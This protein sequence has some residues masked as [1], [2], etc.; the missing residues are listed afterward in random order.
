MAD[1]I[2]PES[3]L[4][5]IAD[6]IQEVAKL[7]EWAVVPLIAVAIG[8]EDKGLQEGAWKW[9]RRLTC[10]IS[11]LYTDNLSL[12]Y[13]GIFYFRLM[14]PF[15]VGFQIRWAGKDPYAKEYFQFGF[16]W[17]GNGKPGINFRRQSDLSAAEGYT[18]ANVG[19]AVGWSDGPK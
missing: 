14:F 6:R 19:Q 8:F 12:Y 11:P 5:R 2:K 3:W 10:R 16:G 9:T 7:P 18:H 1:L 17:K 15:W 13:N 4:N